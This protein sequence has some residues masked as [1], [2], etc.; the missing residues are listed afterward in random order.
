MNSQ[1]KPP[2]GQHAATSP[3]AVSSH[4]GLTPLSAAP[5]I[6]IL[7]QNRFSW[8]GGRCDVPCSECTEP[9]G[10]LVVWG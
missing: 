10:I 9:R 3:F 5:D 2:E 7:L 4:C 6:R 1:I 8:L